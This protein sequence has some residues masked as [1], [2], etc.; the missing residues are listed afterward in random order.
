M[1]K[2]EGLI[3]TD[4]SLPHLALSLGIKTYVLLTLGCEW[5]WTNDEK[6]NWYPNA[7]LL[8]QTELSN[9]KNVINKLKNIL[10]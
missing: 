5:R 2:V 4:T 8:R 10:I 3:S 9:W 1:R 7:I 6:T